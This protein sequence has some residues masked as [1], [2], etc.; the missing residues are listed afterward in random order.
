MG[1]TEPKK[2]WDLLNIREDRTSE[3]LGFLE[4]VA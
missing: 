1:H 2:R 3:K 4:T